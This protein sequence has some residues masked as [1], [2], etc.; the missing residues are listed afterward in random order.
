MKKKI[1]L[2]LAVLGVAATLVPIA[3]AKPSGSDLRGGGGVCICLPAPS[4]A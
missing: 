4:I 1:T 3:Q 2:T